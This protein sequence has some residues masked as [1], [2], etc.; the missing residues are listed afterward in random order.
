MSNSLNID[1]KGKV[2]LVQVETGEVRS[3]LCE[4]G[5]GCSPNTNGRKIF[6]KD[7]ISGER[8]IISGDD[9]IKLAHG[10]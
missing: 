8:G 3:F 7:Y 5:F 1:L 6:G 4:D 9:V 2:V 10:E